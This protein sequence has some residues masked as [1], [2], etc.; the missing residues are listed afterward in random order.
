LKA[1]IDRKSLRYAEAY[2]RVLVQ[3][4]DEESMQIHAGIKQM[5]EQ[6]GQD[7]NS[8]IEDKAFDLEML[9]ID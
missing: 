5:T 2:S 1:L 8:H 4:G 3:R 7:F 9:K 6:E